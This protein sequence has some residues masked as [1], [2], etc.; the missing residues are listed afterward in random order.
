L[1]ALKLSLIPFSIL[2]ATL[3]SRRFGHGIGGIV[4]GLPLIAGPIIIVLLLDH[5]TRFVAHISQ[6]TLTA[7]PAALSHIVCFAW[8]SRRYHWS[9]C[10][11]CAALSFV[12]VGWLVTQPE[13]PSLVSV[14]LA[15]AAPPLALCLMPKVGS[16]AAG[17]VTVPTSELLCRMLAALLMGALI[18]QGS[19]YFSTR[20]SGLLLAWPIT[21]S[22]LPCF[23]LALYGHQATV[24]L[25][26]G[27]ANGLFGFVG[28]FLSMTLLFQFT[29]WKWLAF[30]SAL[31]AALAA[32]VLLHR[33]RSTN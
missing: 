24:N 28:F 25:L 20:T 7:V 27:F 30:V 26:R 32:T 29:E 22:I 14:F 23:T 5:P 8:M 16:A 17:G 4:S 13:I 6:A 11:G 15:L 19:T 12:L 21:G 2:A 1:D 3:V 10:L 31:F 9:I 33:L 18:S